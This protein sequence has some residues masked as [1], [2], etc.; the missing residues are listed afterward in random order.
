MKARHIILLTAMVVELML[1]MEVIVNYPFPFGILWS[2]K[3][4]RTALWQCFRMGALE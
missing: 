3:K 2:T 1:M 4:P